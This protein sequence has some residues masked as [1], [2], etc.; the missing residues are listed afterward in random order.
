MLQTRLTKPTTIVI[1]HSA[2]KDSGTVSWGAIEKYH[3]ETQGW[4]DIGYHAGVELIGDSAYALSGR[5]EWAIAAAVKENLMNALGLHVCVVGDYDVDIPSD[6]VLKVLAERV[7]K[8]W[9]KKYNIVTN[10]IKRHHD[11]ASYKT[12]PGVKFPMDKLRKMCE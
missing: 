8:P 7:V 5:P 11:Y 10:N 9:M 1:H 2:T 4:S 6:V 12:C 3:I